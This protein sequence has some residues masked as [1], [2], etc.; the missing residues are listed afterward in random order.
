MGETDLPLD[1][2][3]EPDNAPAQAVP[4]GTYSL[5]KKKKVIKIEAV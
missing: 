3:V 1:R 5:K 2:W 4:M